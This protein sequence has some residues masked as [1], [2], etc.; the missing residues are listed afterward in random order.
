MNEQLQNDLNQIDSLLDTVKLQGTAYLKNL[1]NRPASVFNEVKLTHK[2]TENGV[3]TIGALQSFNERFEPIM[4]SS[5][6]P[7]YW[8]YVTGGSTPASIAGDWLTSIYDQ[9]SQATEAP[10]DVSANIEIETIKLLLDLFEL[11]G[12]F[13]GGFVTGATMSNFTCLAVARQWLGK[14]MGKDFAKEGISQTIKVLTATPHSSALKAL[15]LLGIGSSNIIKVK[16]LEGNREAIDLTDFEDKIFEL[17]GE[18]FILISSG[19]T[20]NTVDFDDCEG[21]AALKNKYNFWWHIDA[22]FGG[23]A[24]CCATHKHLLNGWQTSDSI[25]IDCHK[26]LNVPYENAVF[27]VKE[28]YNILQ[29]ETFQNSNA[30][31]LGNPMEHFDYLNFLPENSRRLK[32]LPVWFSLVAYGKDG[33]KNIVENN[34]KVAQLF[35]Q[36][37]EQSKYFELLA[38]VR[39][40]TVCFTLSGKNNQ[41]KVKPFLK[42]LNDTGK[43]FMTPT[44]YRGNTGIR[45]AFV[46]WRTTEKD[47]NMVSELMNQIVLDFFKSP[48]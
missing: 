40:N 33:I 37:I 42:K 32:A 30:P 39:L 7:R 19:G 36:F 16:T 21:I 43:V 48:S 44:V 5:S 11:P 15:S 24:I 34:I 26:W 35:G 38:P 20:V 22:A 9:N 31:Y 29:V 2:L 4:V 14:Q 8:G 27:F 12:D 41:E 46:N 28:K 25:T 6:G 17:K 18:P 47:I 13:F 3:G 10:G 1:G 23:F 45:A